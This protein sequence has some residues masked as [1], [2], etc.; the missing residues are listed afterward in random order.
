MLYVSKLLRV[1]A[2]V[3]FEHPGHLHTVAT[4]IMSC[5]TS[6]TLHILFSNPA[7]VKHSAIFYGQA[8]AAMSGTTAVFEASNSTWTAHSPH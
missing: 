8:Q 3:L 2:R 1:R 6:A 7:M 5:Y 4:P